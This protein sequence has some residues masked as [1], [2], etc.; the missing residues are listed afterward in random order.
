MK[1]LKH[2]PLR[3]VLDLKPDLP[4]ALEGLHARFARRKARSPRR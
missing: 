3:P 1:K 4:H 2:D